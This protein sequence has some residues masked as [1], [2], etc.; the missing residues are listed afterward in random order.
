MKKTTKFLLPFLVLSSLGLSSCDSH[1]AILTYGNIE[2]SDY[3]IA[4]L[5]SDYIYDISYEL[6]EE[7][8]IK[9]GKVL[10]GGILKVDNFRYLKRRFL[11]IGRVV[12]TTTGLLITGLLKGC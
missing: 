6:L 1:K 10:D 8:I 3:D 5:S 12:N 2:M 7:K 4:D 11:N 9:E